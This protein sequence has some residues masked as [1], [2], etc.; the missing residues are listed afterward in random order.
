MNN[1]DATKFLKLLIKPKKTVHVEDSIFLDHNP[2]DYTVWTV[3]D[4]KIQE[5]QLGIMLYSNLYD[6]YNLDFKYLK[7]KLGFEKFDLSERKMLSETLGNKQNA[8]LQKA[9]LL[10]V[11]S[12]CGGGSD[13]LN[14]RPGAMGTGYFT[15]EENAKGPNISLKTGKNG[16]IELSY[17]TDDSYEHVVSK[18][19]TVGK[20]SDGSLGSRKVIEESNNFYV[21]HF[22]VKADDLLFKTIKSATN[23][24]LAVATG[25]M[26]V[27]VGGAITAVEETLSA[28]FDVVEN[29][30]LSDKQ[31]QFYNSAIV[32]EN[33]KDFG[34]K[35]VLVTLGT[36]SSE[37]TMALTYPTGKTWPAVDALGECVSGKKINLTHYGF[38]EGTTE[39]TY[40][41]IRSYPQ[42]THNLLIGKP[43]EKFDREAIRLSESEVTFLNDNTYMEIAD[44]R[45]S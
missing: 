1:S 19:V 25:G 30:Q 34:L 11:F 39:I 37:E 42:E 27:V 43:L 12:M 10:D 16:S 22:S 9:A 32:A 14:E 20:V 17:S 2:N 6:T 23:V 28:V 15:S 31:G 36:D 41:M 21:D 26:S 8:I 35:S 24:Y 33:N 18:T 3:D 4:E 29:N 5:L 38:P 40:E 45:N 13:S 44:N 7:E